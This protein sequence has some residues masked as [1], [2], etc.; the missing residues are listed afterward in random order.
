[1]T[2]KE[3]LQGENLERL[4]A[5]LAKVEDLSH[6]FMS[7]LSKR[8]P[9]NAQ[10]SGPDQDVFVKAAT[11]YWSGMLQDPAKLFEN[12]LEFWGNSVKHYLEASQA[13]AKGKLEAPEDTTP[14]DRRFANPFGR[15]TPILTM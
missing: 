15:R 14:T 6:R 11:Q 1:M 12:Q 3:G 4:E 10:L 5:N 13:L 7:A 2:T 8:N 9:A